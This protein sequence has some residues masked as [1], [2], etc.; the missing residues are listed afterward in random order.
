MTGQP[1]CRSLRKVASRLR[2]NSAMS[3]AGSCGSVADAAATEG[4]PVPMDSCQVS[5]AHRLKPGFGQA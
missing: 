1:T 2:G 5:T 3:L 4:R